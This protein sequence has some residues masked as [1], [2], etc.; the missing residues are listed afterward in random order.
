VNRTNKSFG[1]YMDTEYFILYFR[2]PNIG[3]NVS[4]MPKL[5]IVKV[6]TG[7]IVALNAEAKFKELLEK[8]NALDKTH[9]EITK[10][11]TTNMQ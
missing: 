1:P 2:N 10:N 9:Q 3:L 7:S 6:E 5:D 8:Y 4:L 11:Y